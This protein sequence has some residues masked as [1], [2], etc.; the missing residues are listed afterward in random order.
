MALV[1]LR[2]EDP[3]FKSPLRSEGHWVT[4]IAVQSVTAHTAVATKWGVGRGGNI[5]YAALSF[6]HDGQDKN[7][8][9]WNLHVPW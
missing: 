2:S 1:K 4:M 7:A 3:E 5:M 6:L 9:K 8:I